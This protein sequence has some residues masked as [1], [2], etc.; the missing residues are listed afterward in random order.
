MSNQDVADPVSLIA[1]A[2]TRLARRLRSARPEHAVSLSTLALLSALHRKG[3]MPAVQLAREEKLKPQSLTRLL[4]RMEADGL[5]ERHRD[6]RDQRVL[7]SGLTREGRAVVVR[8]M[9][10]RRAWLEQAMEMALDPAE[11]AHLTSAADLMLKV[12]GQEPDTRRA[13]RRIEG[14]GADAAGASA[15]IPGVYYDDAR[16]GIAWLE[17]ALGFDMAEAF[18]GPGGKIAYAQMTFCDGLLFVSSKSRNTPWSVVGKSAILLN[19]PD[20]DDVKRRWEMAVAAGA[21][22][23]R[24][25]RLSV[26]PAF[27]DGLQ[28][29]DV[30]DPEGNLWAITEFRPRQRARPS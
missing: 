24:P 14:R 30:R 29:F 26:T 22:V 7:L 25:L 16:A 17:A 3:P 9:A 21:D 13:F 10:S 2:V 18:E 23:V 12:A 1:R 15:V 11:R 6:E 19:A 28:Q 5:I 8:D 27:P 20:G 4:A